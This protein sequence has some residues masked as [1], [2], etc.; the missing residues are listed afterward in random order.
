MTRYSAKDYAGAV[1][2]LQP[3][4]D[5]SPD[6]AHVQFFLGI[7]QLMSGKPAAAHRIARPRGGERQRAV[8]G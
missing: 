1:E 5:A 3:L 7:S 6:A 2:Q 8:R 4:A